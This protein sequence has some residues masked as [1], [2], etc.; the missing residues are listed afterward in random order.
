MTKKKR[1]PTRADLDAKKEFIKDYFDER[2]KRLARARKLI[3]EEEYFLEGILVLCCHIAS[4]SAARFPAWQ[5]NNGFKEILLRYSGKRG[6]Y[7]KIDLLFLYQWRRSKFREHG[8]YVAFKNYAEVKKILFRKF[9][10]ENAIWSRKR[11]VSKGSIIKQVMAHRFPGLD[12]KNLKTSLPLFSVAEQTYRYL[13]C[14]A[15][16]N[17][18]FP[19]ISRRGYETNHLVDKALLIETA[20]G[21]LNNLERECLR[22]DK[23]PWQLMQR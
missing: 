23:F 7:Q 2:R 4:F 5:D 16:H 10:D 8:H 21:I 22:Q 12:V 15:V 14:S 17:M 9:G 18:Q 20:E 6:L 1:V 11:F 13:R 3:D 19:L